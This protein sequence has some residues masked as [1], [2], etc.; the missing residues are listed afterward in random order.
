MLLNM[1]DPES[2]LKWWRVWPERHD[3]YLE[4][5]LKSSPEFAPSIRAAQSRIASSIELSG[6]LAG[7]VRERRE[8]LAAVALEDMSSSAYELRREALA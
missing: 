2:I 1:N 5:V 7:S 3:A 6:L 4:H 8:R